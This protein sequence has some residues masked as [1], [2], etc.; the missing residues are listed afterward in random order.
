MTAA[1]RAAAPLL[2]NLTVRRPDA[3]GQFGFSDPRRVT[4]ILEASGW[5]RIDVRPIDAE[6]ALSES[7]LLS[8]LTRLGP[9]G[10]VLPETD[11]LTRARVI[12]AVRAAFEPYFRGADVR[13]VAACWMAGAQ[14]P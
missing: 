1:E 9:L 3:P 7:A 5:T 14:A 10:R 6:C 8:Y 2:P 12:E 4:R 13:F 11:R